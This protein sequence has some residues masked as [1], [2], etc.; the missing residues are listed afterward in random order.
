MLLYAKERKTPIGDFSGT[1]SGGTSFDGELGLVN[2]RIERAW[3]NDFLLFKLRLHPMGERLKC[4]KQ[5][6][7][8]QPST[9]K[10]RRSTGG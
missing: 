5:R 9:F 7:T 3:P 6:L 4:R 10:I 2:E 8:G 1:S